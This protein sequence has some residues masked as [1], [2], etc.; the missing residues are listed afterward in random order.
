MPRLVSH[1][2]EV[3]V[4]SRRF[5]RAMEEL[6]GITLE[7]VAITSTVARTDAQGAYD[8]CAVSCRVTGRNAYFPLSPAPWTSSNVKPVAVSDD[9]M[10][11]HDGK[12]S[13]VSIPR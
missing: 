2:D 7:S 4:L 10:P 3:K 12:A 5:A 6:A 9:S 13:D 1:P 8:A 11:R